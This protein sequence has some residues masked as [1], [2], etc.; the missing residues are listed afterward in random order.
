MAVGSD[1]GVPVL[2]NRRYMRIFRKA[3][4]ANA[5]MGSNSESRGFKIS[6]FKIEGTLVIPDAVR[7]FRWQC[8]SRFADL[9][10]L[11]QMLILAIF[12]V[13]SA[14]V[15]PCTPN[16]QFVWSG[17][18]WLLGTS[19]CAKEAS[20]VMRQVFPGVPGN[21][22]SRC[23]GS[24]ATHYIRL[25]LV[26]VIGLLCWAPGISSVLLLRLVP[27]SLKNACVRLQFVCHA[28]ESRDGA[29]LPLGLPHLEPTK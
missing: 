3:T 19:V 25:G 27:A 11:D 23:L 26:P 14:A 13:S 29:S 17:Q 10:D 24:I 21:P 5:V 15:L 28:L 4:D 18:P 8:A 6:G 20:E 12:A 22:A 2:C 16:K 1:F 7:L 9:R